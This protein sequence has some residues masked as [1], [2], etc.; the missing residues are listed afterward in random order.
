MFCH[1]DVHLRHQILGTK[2]LN[3]C[4]SVPLLVTVRHANC[5]NAMCLYSEIGIADVALITLPQRCLNALSVQGI[6]EGLI[7]Q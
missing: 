5:V 2:G 4:V 7:N 3:Q 6:S 1:S